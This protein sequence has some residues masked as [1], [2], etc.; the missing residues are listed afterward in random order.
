[1]T[2]A[3]RDVRQHRTGKYTGTILW[4]RGNAITASIGF[5]T[6]RELQRVTLAYADDANG[7]NPVKQVLRLLPSRTQSDGVRWWLACVHCD[8]RCGRLHLAHGEDSFACRK[9]LDLSYDSAQQA[10]AVERLCLK[11]GISPRGIL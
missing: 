1:M 7:T 8:R 10:H 2:F 9:C 6:D 4:L 5:K 3:A 11:L